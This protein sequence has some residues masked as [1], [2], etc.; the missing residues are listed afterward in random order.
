MLKKNSDT[1]TASP[2]P[3]SSKFRRLLDKKVD[4]NCTHILTRTQGKVWGYVSRQ[5]SK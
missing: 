2:F 1:E 4:K 5:D 3:E